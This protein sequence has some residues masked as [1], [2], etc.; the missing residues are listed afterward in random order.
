MSSS[1]SH[2][3]GSGSSPCTTA[4][5]ASITT[6]RP[7]PPASTTPASARGSHTVG[8]R[9]SASSPASAAAS[10]RGASA[11]PWSEAASAASATARATASRPPGRGDAIE[12]DAASAPASSASASRPASTA[13]ALRHTSATPPRNENNRP[14]ARPS[15]GSAAVGTAAANSLSERHDPTASA[16]DDSA[17]AEWEPVFPLPSDPASSRSRAGACATM[18]SAAKRTTSTR[19]PAVNLLRTRSTPSVRSIRPNVRDATDGGGRGMHPPAPGSLAWA[20]RRASARVAEPF[21]GR[22]RA[23][24]RRP[25]HR[26]ALPTSHQGEPCPPSVRSVRKSRASG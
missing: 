3:G 11:A 4:T 8:V 2:A 9:S 16:T 18:A 7:A 23:A 6:M 12:W 25:G 15:D 14:P 20:A 13:S 1:N 17:A 22:S 21:G 26:E 10:T 24:D 5:S 19:S